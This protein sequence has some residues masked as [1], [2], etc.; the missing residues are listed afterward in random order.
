M[1][2]IYSPRQWLSLF[3][4]LHLFTFGNTK[5][6]AEGEDLGP[7]PE[8]EEEL[9][10]EPTFNLEGQVGSDGSDTVYA[11]FYGPSALI[12]TTSALEY[13]VDQFT[14]RFTYRL[15]V[16]V[17][18]ARHAFQPTLALQ[19]NSRGP[20][21]LCGVG[22]N[23]TFDSISRDTSRG[24]PV[25]WHS[26]TGLPAQEYDDAMGFVATVAG[27][28]YKL[29]L[30]SEST[31]TP[32]EFHPESDRGS[33]LRFLYYKADGYWEVL[34]KAGI[35]Y[36]FGTTPNS[37]LTNPNWTI[38]TT[39]LWA[40]EGAVDPNGNT[41]AYSYT[42]LAGT[43][44]PSQIDYGG[45]QNAPLIPHTARIEFEF[46]TENE[47][48]DKPISLRS[49][50]RS[51][52][53]KRLVNIRTRAGNDLVQRYNLAY[54]QSPYTGKSMLAAVT[55]FG[56]NDVESLP[57]IQFQYQGMSWRFADP[58][59]WDSGVT[60]AKVRD[61]LDIDGDALPDVVKRADS[62]YYDPY[63]VA[64]NTGTGFTPGSYGPILSQK[65]TSAYWTKPKY[66]YT[67][68]GNAIEY[69]GMY[70]I[71]ADGFPDRVETSADTPRSIFFVGLNNGIRSASWGFSNLF[72]FWFPILS[73]E[74]ATR[75]YS[76]GGWKASS[77]WVN[78]HTG[79]ID[80]N[81][82]GLPDRFL[83]T[84]LM[85]TQH[86]FQVNMAND[87]ASP[88]QQYMHMFS[89]LRKWQTCV[90]GGIT[91]NNGSDISQKLLDVNGDGLPD[92][93]YAGSGGW[94]GGQNSHRPPGLNYTYEYGIEFNIGTGFEI[95]NP[96]SN[97]GS[98]SWFENRDH[99]PV[100]PP[101][102]VLSYI[103][104]S[105]KW[106]MGVLQSDVHP[107]EPSISYPVNGTFDINGDGLPDHVFLTQN[108]SPATL[109]VIVNNGGGFTNIS[110]EFGNLRR[111][112]PSDIRTMGIGGSKYVGW[113]D[114]NGDGLADRV[115]R[116][117][118][119]S[120]RFYIQ[121]NEGPIPDLLTNIV[122]GLG[123]NVAIAYKPSTQ[124]D[125]HDDEGR[126]RLP[127]VLYV[128]SSIRAND[129]IGS[130]STN[131]FGYMGGLFDPQR[132]EFSGFYRTALTNS[133]KAYTLTY[134]HQGG[135]RT[136]VGEFQDVNVAKRGIPFKIESF[137]SDG[138]LY[139][140]V[141]N[142]VEH[143][144][145]PNA[146]LFAHISQTVIQDYEGLTSYRA[147]A[148]RFVYDAAT[149]NLLRA[150]NLGEVTNVNEA[151][152][153][154]DILGPQSFQISEYSPI[155]NIL[156]LPNSVRIA[157]DSAGTARLR[158]TKFIYDGNGNLLEQTAWH[159]AAFV[160][161]KRNTYDGYGNVATTTNAM[162]VGTAI[163]YDSAYVFP[164]TAS[165][166]PG[167]PPYKYVYD[168]RSGRL[169]L[170]VEP[171]GLVVSN[172][173]DAL[174]RPVE[175]RI[176][177]IP[178]GVADTWQTKVSYSLGGVANGVS[179][180]Y[181][182][183]KVNDATDA[184]GHQT[185]QYTDGLGRTIQSKSE[186]ERAGD[187][188][189][190]HTLYDSSGRP[191][192]VTHPYFTNGPGFT[193]LQGTNVG[194]MTGYD[195]IGRVAT[196]WSAAALVTTANGGEWDIVTGDAG[197]A[198]GYSTVA[199]RDGNNLWTTVKTDARGNVKK[200]L[201][202]ARG[203]TWKIQELVGSDVYET[204][205]GYDLLDQLIRVTNDLE[206]V[207]SIEYDSLGNKT[208]LVD[209]D[210]GEWN[211]LHDAAGRLL[212]QQDPNGHY[213]D[214]DYSSDPLGRLTWK[215]VYNQNGTMVDYAG[216]AYYPSGG[217]PAY[218]GQ[219]G[220]VYTLHNQE[221]YGYDFQGRRTAKRVIN[222]DGDFTFQHTYDVADR[223][224][225]VTYLNNALKVKYNY[226]TGGNM[227]RVDI[228]AGGPAPANGIIYQANS[229][230]EVG[231]PESITHGNGLQTT[232]SHYRLTKRV[233]NLKTT[234]HGG[235]YHQDLTYTFDASGNVLTLADNDASHNGTSL[236]SQFSAMQYD[237]LDRL[238]YYVRNG[239][240]KSFTYDSLGNVRTNG[241]L[242][243]SSYQYGSRPHAVTQATSTH[244]YNY[245]AAGNMTYRPCQYLSYDEQ[246]RLVMLNNCGTYQ[247]FAY[248]DSG[249]LLLQRDGNG[250]VT[251]CFIDDL[252][253]R[254][255]SRVWLHVVHAG[256]KI[257]SFNA[258]ATVA[259]YPLHDALGSVKVVTDR[260]GAVLEQNT[261]KAYGKLDYGS[262]G[263]IYS[264]DRY[265]GQTY[266]RGTTS[267]YGGSGLYWYNSRFY[268]PEIGRF[269]Q[270]DT[271]V[272]SLDDP[273]TLNR[274]TYVLNNP[275]RY[276]DPSG[277]LAW[278]FHS[279]F[280]GYYS[281]M[282]YNTPSPMFTWGGVGHFAADALWNTD[283]IRVAS[284]AFTAPDFTSI[285]G[286]TFTVASWILM[287]FVVADAAVNTVVPLKAG[288]T[289]GL[290]VVG[291]KAVQ[292]GGEQIGIRAAKTVAN[293]LPSTMA[294]VIPEG[295]PA[296][297]L[298][299]PGA[300]DVFVTAA[301]DIAGM[302]ASQI[303]NRLGIP[304]SP[305][306]FRVFEFPT[307]QS[308]VAS[309]VFRTDP[310]FIGGGLTSGGAREFVI[311]NGP[312]PPGAVRT[313]P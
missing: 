86:L 288:V 155:G 180:N 219:L 227:H 106:S 119:Q 160:S 237:A 247:T 132:R 73:D 33:Y 8:F 311:P 125:N 265:T 66:I 147:R 203:R 63:Q 138:A 213:I 5:G 93:I 223:V 177:S 20:N 298:G 28:S 157:S 58:V 39:F 102:G 248:T 151:A 111:A 94:S 18:P 261:Y 57:P 14:G 118:D 109:K 56:T 32:L 313:V 204:L 169:V 120:G 99:W 266:V 182:C 172:M 48:P 27:T 221:Y 305:T 6:H 141:R 280:G 81:G 22:W 309:P 84:H 2:T 201:S 128:V 79:L 80:M 302:N 26:D 193:P 123:A 75:N 264:S 142:K 196:V 25:K 304:Q 38:P 77:S 144:P 222:E 195:E 4:L 97:E 41:I 273:Q 263:F 91:R 154:F 271:I 242:A 257:A 209:P 291:K 236:S 228:L 175:T 37:R 206:H 256:R 168:R 108:T 116:D 241:E 252:Y 78:G 297:T 135:G 96:P 158:E 216:Y 234:K 1:A 71:N 187:Y 269:V 49:N 270:P 166:I 165:S 296:T 226:D 192:F 220:A 199:Y 124:Y 276:N 112:K 268:D 130:T 50:F 67:G 40:L 253:E 153:T 145:R 254:D 11:D 282:S 307:P 21:G 272:P 197:S 17:P 292:T 88:F 148:S 9:P 129:G 217:L 205:Y 174:L 274:Y 95:L 181:V 133:S 210:A 47:R 289:G 114:V 275:F 90:D 23:L 149:G 122:N 185:Y 191:E 211:Y 277:H 156:N 186:S 7:L 188:R 235:G 35:R 255:D 207:T 42:K 105:G 178:N 281:G 89:D 300:A 117:P 167:F 98:H 162:G 134:H 64:F 113:F 53:R 34:D 200:L 208:K 215:G 299:R 76:V 229:F 126:T 285:E 249:Q 233:Q 107:G 279:G 245:D 231:D 52:I 87:P 74:E 240:I 59:L 171:T 72:N 115:M 262:L 54:E 137:G 131:S 31:A 60:G 183:I 30:A 301:D 170:S 68:S 139:R 83:S 44:Y 214:F 161:V 250:T 3:L 251:Q 287:P 225:E 136:G 163:S 212:T 82:D 246:N 69:V 173:Y 218:Y 150:E 290:K 55:I 70:D 202:D 303:A 293:P 103:S 258:Q 294:R 85:D 19:Y 110:G 24:V 230:N 267:V 121:L 100:F 283:T 16:N 310:G 278:E 127:F 164:T 36:Q 43:L 152:G 15:R 146:G 198:A 46:S 224:S 92:K 284:E 243:G 176:S 101:N 260:Y 190:V 10:L 13:E 61:F 45:N 62:P 308:G 159:N 189:T 295:I 65:P 238:V 143:V 194:T 184:D 312:I 286:G 179:A 51:E 239:V 259:L 232:K 306:G 29:V 244:Y 12:P 140:V 104:S